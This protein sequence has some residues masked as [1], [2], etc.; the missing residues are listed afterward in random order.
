MILR[1]DDTYT[2]RLSPPSEPK[3]DISKD[4]RILQ[5]VENR[6]KMMIQLH[7]KVNLVLR[8]WQCRISEMGKLFN[9]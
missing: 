2:L 8:I 9:Y 5:G 7:L 1:I 4:N 6:L 3:I